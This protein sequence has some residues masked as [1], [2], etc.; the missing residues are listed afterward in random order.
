MAFLAPLGC[1]RALQRI[2]WGTLALI[3]INLLIYALASRDW[4]ATDPGLIRA[5]GLVPDDFAA[6][7]LVT[8][9]F[10][11]SGIAHLAW[12]LLFLGIFGAPVEE[13]L[14]RIGFL[15]LYLAGGAASAL[16]HLA[17]SYAFYAPGDPYRG[18]PAIGASGAIAALLGLFA[19]RLHQTKLGLGVWLMVQLAGGVVALLWTGPDGG[20]GYWAHIGGF[21]FGLGAGYA[22]QFYWKGHRDHMLAAAR[23]ALT[24]SP[25]RAVP[26]LEL[27]LTQEPENT[28]LH[29][30][31]ARAWL[32][33]GDLE[34]A[35]PHLRQAIEGWQAAGQE[36]EAIALY[37]EAALPYLL[38][39][40]ARYRLASGFERG[41]AAREALALYE[42]LRQ[43]SDPALQELALLRAAQ[44]HLSRLNAPAEA[45]SLFEAFLRAYPK[46]EWTSFAATGLEQA[47]RLRE[48]AG[49][50]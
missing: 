23:A 13:A 28:A 40:A 24:A 5:Y 48:S 25:A 30:D 14:G 34:A 7:Q 3:G 2:P 32:R 6:A 19:V 1:D 11:H 50:P 21:L 12:N 18:L 33:L 26:A 37:R 47:R 4:R 20:V 41:G 39:E 31:L 43:A 45:A 42:S 16:V 36:G 49:P 38:S 29:G 9:M 44:I 35:C 27:L 46:S 22:F 17:V 15:L 8:W 10:L